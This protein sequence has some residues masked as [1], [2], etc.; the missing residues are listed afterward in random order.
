VAKKW[1][2]LEMFDFEAKK[3]VGDEGLEPPTTW[4]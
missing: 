4:V 1:L 2:E 3:M